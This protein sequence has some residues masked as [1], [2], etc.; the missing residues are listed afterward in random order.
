MYTRLNC[1]GIWID[2]FELIVSALEHNN[3]L[4]ELCLMPSSSVVESSEM[5]KERRRAGRTLLGEGRV[6][7]L[8]SA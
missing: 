8:H 5:T 3:T 1:R 4:R 2:S 6:Y 7:E